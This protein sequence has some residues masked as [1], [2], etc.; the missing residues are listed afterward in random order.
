VTEWQNIQLPPGFDWQH[1]VARWDRMQERYLVRRRERIDT[2]VRLVRD[3]QGNEPFVVDL[4][5][6][7]G[8]LMSALLQALPGARVLGIDF[9]PMVLLLGRAR[10]AA[11]SPR[12]RFC[13]AD[14]R[15]LDWSQTP[16]LGALAISADQARNPRGSARIRVQKGPTQSDPQAD[17]VVSATA[18]HWLTA[19]E[20]AAI[21]RQVACIL[22]PGGLFVNAD[23]VGSEC[24]A[25][26]RG[27][28]RHR[29]QMRDGEGHAEAEG[30][31]AFWTA[32]AGAL[33]VDVG[34]IDQRV[35]GGW[36]GG[37]ED[38]LPLAW[39]LDALRANGFHPVDCFWR[40]DCDAIYGGILGESV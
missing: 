13:F 2:V 23:H 9:D 18:L 20:L 6:G 28:E 33:G 22:R 12:A 24:E 29:Q 30:W 15:S 8:S 1:W 4:G 25:I 31:D 35:L 27:W 10:L 17:A 34:T 5:C 38:G 37:I 26:Q 21:Y 7:P 19:D 36:E 32:Y 39:H 16:A 3:T 40:C 14:L 11:Y